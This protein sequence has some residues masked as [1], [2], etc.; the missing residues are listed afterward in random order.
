MSI[1]SNLVLFWAKMAV[2][3]WA[4]P[5]FS[6]PHITGLWV[7]FRGATCCTQAP[8]SVNF[9]YRPRIQMW[10][11]PVWKWTTNS[12]WVWNPLLGFKTTGQDH[13]DFVHLYI[14]SMVRTDKMFTT[15]ESVQ[16]CNLTGIREA[17][18]LWRFKDGDCDLPGD[19]RSREV[20]D[21]Q[22]HDRRICWNASHGDK[23]SGSVALSWAEYMLIAGNWLQVCWWT[24]WGR[25][26]C[27]G[28]KADQWKVRA[29]IAGLV[30]VS[31]G[32]CSAMFHVGKTSTALWPWPSSRCYQVVCHGKRH[33]VNNPN[34]SVAPH[35]I[36][37]LLYQLWRQS[38]EKKK[39]QMPDPGS[40]SPPWW[41]CALCKYIFL[42]LANKM[43]FK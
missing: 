36:S 16:T 40:G 23:L 11:L 38:G 33:D 34:V 12:S 26:W 9:R 14:P 27:E 30:I 17:S 4:W 15:A 19:R 28:R 31:V 21:G 35:V 18:L 24:E 39:S 8:I 37:H 20:R 42:W 25:V 41:T 10:N 43:P 5:K 6:S 29:L 3:K 13:N 22:D 32:L 7:C 1:L 2:K